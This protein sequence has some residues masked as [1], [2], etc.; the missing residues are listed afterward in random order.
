MRDEQ[1]LSSS[2]HIV[3]DQRY[4]SSS[5]TVENTVGSPADDRT[6]FTHTRIRKLGV[7]AM[8]WLAGSFVWLTMVSQVVVAD[9]PPWDPTAKF[10]R[11]VLGVTYGVYGVPI[12]LALLTVLPF[13]SR[14]K[15]RLLVASLSSL[16]AITSGATLVLLLA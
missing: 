5:T 4:R 16:A 8:A 11:R 7:A 13:A 10:V 6:A 2:Q 9:A 14:I 1:R 15:Y 12:A 3:S